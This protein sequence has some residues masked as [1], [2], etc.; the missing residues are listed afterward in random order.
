[1][2]REEQEGRVWR[3]REKEDESC[4]RASEWQMN[5]ERRE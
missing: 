3:T 2:R 4:E 1:M 5:G